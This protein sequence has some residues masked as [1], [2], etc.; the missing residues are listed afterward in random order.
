MNRITTEV[1]VKLWWVAYC[2]TVAAIVARMF[3][4]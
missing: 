2:L 1:I 3:A 4:R